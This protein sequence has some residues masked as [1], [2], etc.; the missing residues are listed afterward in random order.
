MTDDLNKLVACSG[1]LRDGTRACFASTSVLC[2]F[3]LG[4][5]NN[6]LRGLTLGVASDLIVRGG[7]N[8]SKPRPGGPD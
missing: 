1:R 5:A 7:Y 2:C 6:R 3:Q 8:L 4:E